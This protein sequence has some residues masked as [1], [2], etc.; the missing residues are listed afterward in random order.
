[1]RVFKEGHKKL[2]EVLSE[3]ANAIFIAPTSYGKSK[4][5]PIIQDELKMPRSVH[6]MPLR[7]LVQQQLSYL[8]ENFGSACHASGLTLEGKCPYMG[9]KRVVATIDYLSLV[10]MRLPPP[11]LGFI[12]SVKYN[13]YGHHEYPRANVFTSLIVMDEAHLMGEPWSEKPSQGRDFLYAVSDVAKEFE[14][15]TIITTATLPKN[16]V[17]ELSKTLSAKIVAVCEKCY[18]GL[19]NVIRVKP[20]G[21]INPKW[22]TEVNETSL[23]DYVSKNFKEI[24]QFPGKVLIVANTVPK[25]IS[26]WKTLKEKGLE[27]VIVHGRL[28]D[29]DKK[30]ALEKIE[31]AKVVV[32]TQVIEAG[33]DVNA[34][35]LITESAPISSLAQRAGRLCREEGCSEAKVT[36]LPGEKP[37]GKIAIE[38]F[39]AINELKEKGIEWR[40]LDDTESGVS[41]FKLVDEL[42]A[43]VKG[44]K[45]KSTYAYA[46]T[47]PL[48]DVKGISEFLVDSCSFVRDSA[49]IGVKVEDQVLELSLDW[50]KYNLKN[51][52]VKDIVISS[53][54]E[55]TSLR[56]RGELDNEV[57]KLENTKGKGLCR[58]YGNLLKKYGGASVTIL[59]ENA[60]FRGLGLDVDLKK[61]M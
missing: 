3:G 48:P 38:T 22:K 33:V 45:V 28:S 55:E 53:F 52:K 17:K 61:G 6:A 24:E 47:V 50:I 26:I 41:F 13:H 12:L 25:A 4:A 39:Q 59:L 7:S 58:W 49:L 34:D 23:E 1:M 43:K 11:E 30:E 19:N 20:E 46:M 27:P 37:Y 29:E 35:W 16:E 56:E 8:K 54:G 42:E 32:S 44:H 57:K 10:L 9:G 18:E 14:L 15:K 2:L 5:V 31:K 40:L 21:V 36:V 51:I 60:Y